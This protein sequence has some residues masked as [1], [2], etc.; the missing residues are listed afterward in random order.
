MDYILLE[1][2]A[3]GYE[4][5]LMRTDMFSRF[6]FAVPTKDQMTWTIIKHW[7]VYYSCPAQ[8]HTDQCHNFEASTIKELCQTNGIAKSRTSPYHLQENAQ[9][10]QFNRTMHKMLRSLSTCYDRP[11]EPDAEPGIFQRQ[12]RLLYR[13]LVSQRNQ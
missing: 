3:G 11:Q 12:S 13:G 9:C 2:S 7:F 5:V 1:P 8:L 4:N 10:K 6:T